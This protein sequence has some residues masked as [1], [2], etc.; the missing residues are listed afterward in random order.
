MRILLADDDTDFVQLMSYAL[1]RQGYRVSTA[2]DGSQALRRWQAETPD[3]VILDLVMP[4]LDG[5][6]VCRRIREESSVPIIM[7]SGRHDEAAIVRGYEGGADDYIVKPFSHRQLIVRIDALIR[8]VSHGGQNGREHNPTGRLAVGDLVIE[9]AA[10]QVWK[11]G[12]LLSLT[13]LEFR[14]LCRLVQSAD[15]LVETQD[16]ATFAWQSPS[17]GDAGLLKTHVS[18]IRQKLTSAGGAPIEIRAIPRTGYIL[19]AGSESARAPIAT[20]GARALGT[21]AYGGLTAT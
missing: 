10:F 6:E 7:M 21:L 17:D 9:P 18:H 4:Q 8:R 15:R 14:V 13:R 11:A 1:L 20:N 5:V 2:Y 3:L 12:V 16:L 19:S